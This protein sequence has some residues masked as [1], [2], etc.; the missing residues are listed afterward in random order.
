MILSIHLTTAIMPASFQFSSE[1]FYPI[2]DLLMSV[3]LN[4]VSSVV[5]SVLI[6]AMSWL[7]R[8]KPTSGDGDLV[9]GDSLSRWYTMDDAVLVLVVIS[10]LGVVASFFVHGK[11]LRWEQ[12]SQARRLVEEENG[13]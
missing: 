4:T 6:A 12:D 9:S 5:S 3:L 13:R 10:G 7:D 1:L 2:S 11:L 8:T